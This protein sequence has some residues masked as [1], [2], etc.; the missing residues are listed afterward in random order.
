M[1]H[2]SLHIALRVAL[3]VIGL[4]LA[5]FFAEPDWEFAE[6][7]YYFVNLAALPALA[8]YA[9]WPRRGTGGFLSGTKSS[10]RITGLYSLIMTAFFFV[11]YG[12]IDK[13]FFPSHYEKLIG[14]ELGAAAERGEEL[15]AEEVREKVESFFSLRN[16]TAILLAGYMALSLFYSLFFSALRSILP[17]RK[18]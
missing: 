18:N 3:A 2:P 14:G 5:L 8:L 6:P 10:L 4:R 1:Q 12:Y 13:E 16:A 7:F 17:K 9:V 11:Y 15:T